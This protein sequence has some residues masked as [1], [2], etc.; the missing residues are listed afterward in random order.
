MS[1]LDWMVTLALTI[2][3]VACACETY[4]LARTLIN[5]DLK[6]RP[7][8][9]NRDFFN[10]EY[11]Q[12]YQQVQKIYLEKLELKAETVRQ[13]NQKLIQDSVA[14]LTREQGKK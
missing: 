6:K 4:V 14:F 5:D 11:N 3:I 1:D 7:D 10:A 2:L 12:A 9:K 8:S 13:R